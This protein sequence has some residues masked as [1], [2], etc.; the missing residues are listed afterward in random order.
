MIEQKSATP[1][2]RN[3][4]EL[5]YFCLWTISHNATLFR[6]VFLGEEVGCIMTRKFRL[7]LYG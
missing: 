5:F 3:C 7:Y 6:I 2:R 4:L 1:K